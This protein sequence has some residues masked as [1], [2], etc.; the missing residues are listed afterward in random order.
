MDPSS[1]GH[2][3]F[4][5]IDGFLDIF[6]EGEGKDTMELD[7]L[8]DFFKLSDDPLSSLPKDGVDSFTTAGGFPRYTCRAMDLVA[9]AGEPVCW[10]PHVT[11]MNL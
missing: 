7:S 9:E 4:D 8:A 6:G 5:N 10:L 1:P 3:D 2:L 11:C